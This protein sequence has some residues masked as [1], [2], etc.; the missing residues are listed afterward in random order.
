MPSS[1]LNST[2]HLAGASVTPS[3]VVRDQH[4]WPTLNTHL[5]DEPNKP[6]SRP[7]R[8]YLNKHPLFAKTLKI[9]TFCFHWETYWILSP[10]RRA[11]ADNSLT[12][13]IYQ[14]PTSDRCSPFCISRK[15]I[16]SWF[17]AP[18]AWQPLK[19]EHTMELALP[20]NSLPQSESWAIEQNIPVFHLDIRFD[21]S[22]WG[23]CLRSSA[24]LLIRVRVEIV[25]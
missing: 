16:L 6:N 2:Q 18:G 11:R 19:Y 24:C 13:F 8:R 21:T 25:V 1:N 4:S 20:L 17:L 7:P 5:C 12:C 22:S 15:A 9:R 14:P 3:T 10:S 23:A